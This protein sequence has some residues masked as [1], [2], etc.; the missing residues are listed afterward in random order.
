LTVQLLKES[1]MRRSLLACAAVAVASLVL[2]GRAGA[3]KSVSCTSK[4]ATAGQ[5]CSESSGPLVAAMVPSTHHPKINAKW[6]L[7]VSATLNGK[8]AHASAEY[9]FLLGYTVVSTQYPRSNKHFTFV[10]HFSDTLVFPPDASGEP[11]TLQV[12]IEDAGHTAKLDWAITA[13]AK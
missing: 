13:G 2:A 3:A 1:A 4:A 7:E 6:P 10:G 8:A 9:Q 11:L 5:S 12:V